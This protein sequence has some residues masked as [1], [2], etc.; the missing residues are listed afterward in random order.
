MTKTS[1]NF[2]GIP[3]AWQ[4]IVTAPKDGTTIFVWTGKDEFP[5]RYEASWREPTDSEYWVSGSDEPNPENQTFGPEAGWFCDE[6]TTWKLD[7]I[8]F[9][10]HW[11]PLPLPPSEQPD[12][13]SASEPAFESFMNAVH[14]YG[15]TGLG[16][17]KALM[18]YDEAKSRARQTD[19][20]GLDEEKLLVR[21]RNAAFDCYRSEDRC[22]EDGLDYE[23]A[24][25][26]FL[27]IIRPC[28]RIP[29]SSVMEVLDNAVDVMRQTQAILEHLH[30][31]VKAAGVP[32]MA[33][34]IGIMS[35]I[36][37]SGAHKVKFILPRIEAAIAAIGKQ[38]ESA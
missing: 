20:E 1:N 35:S 14:E 34:K 30:P 38:M 27:E 9:P 15:P 13:E 8:A 33:R 25:R 19:R 12:S 23:A 18:K 7:G 32:P 28:L 37:T 3:L 6:F 24:S 2:S 29:A 16:Y 10:T 5:N 22:G 21:L 4:D 26:Q 31:L 11:M 36:A 17:R